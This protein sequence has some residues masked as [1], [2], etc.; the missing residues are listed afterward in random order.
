MRTHRIERTTTTHGADNKTMMPR[1]EI[2]PHCCGTSPRIIS[3]SRN[4][5]R[6]RKSALVYTLWTI[7]HVC[8]S[9]IA[10]AAVADVLD[11]SYQPYLTTKTVSAALLQC[12]P[13]S[14][15]DRVL[16]IDVSSSNLG[17][18]GLPAILSSLRKD[19]DIAS[20]RQRT[21]DL[22]AQMNH[23]T[24]SGVTAFLKSLHDTTQ[25]REATH[26]PILRSLDVGWNR[27]CTED[28]NNSNRAFHKALQELVASSSCPQ[29]LSLS[30]TGLGPATC[31]ALAKGLLARFSDPNT[32]RSSR[33]QLSLQL[34]CNHEIGD[35]GAA[36]LAAAIRS[37]VCNS[38]NNKDDDAGIQI[39][40]TLDLSACDIGDVGADALALALEEASV[41]II[42]RLILS[43]N[44]ISDQGALSLGRALQQ[45]QQLASKDH[46]LHL[47]LSNNPKITD[48]GI[49]TLFAAVEKGT[50]TDV[51][52]RSCSIHADGADLVGKALRVFAAGAAK[53]ADSKCLNVDLSGNP[54]G[55]L[56]GKSKPEGGKYSASLLKSKA[57]ATASA[58]VTQGLSFLKKGLGPG[59]STA[60][61]DDEEEKQQASSGGL[62]DDT[63]KSD[64]KR[65]GFKALANAFVGNEPQQHH[66]STSD[67]STLATTRRIHLGLRRTF[68]DT[69]GADALAAMRVAVM[70]DLKSVKLELELDL[71]PVVQDDM[72]AAL[73]GNGDNEDLLR[74][75]A[76]RHTEAMEI[77]RKA[78]ARAAEAARLVAARR[79]RQA[80][81]FDDDYGYEV[82]ADEPEYDG[83]DWDSDADYEDD[84]Y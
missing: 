37:I 14:D 19:D 20:S 39:L 63:E 70:D 13:P 31:R 36:A 51:T 62:D 72:V 68:C 77:I 44:R 42:R 48:R 71:N 10:T 16:L 49:A 41:P 79:R 74:E 58:Y 15:S 12:A 50:L 17:D 32:T 57:S 35:A 66:D 67:S 59:F 40:D 43:H 1:S 18:E 73:Q 27:L 75:M 52:L 46:E 82:P 21:F 11:L 22:K 47:D 56:R 28:N 9:A 24:G 83:G 8:S 30:C 38:N 2:T 61:S 80:A 69:A 60:E 34:S 45:H 7:L 53:A 54:L 26:R 65:C 29:T 64:N 55:V 5:R 3:A 25:D 84:E 81:D 6:R 33:S 23:L 4:S 76:E 78:Q